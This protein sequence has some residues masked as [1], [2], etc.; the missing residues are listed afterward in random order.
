MQLGADKVELRSH[1]GGV[2]AMGELAGRGG[3]CWKLEQPLLLAAVT[4]RPV[5]R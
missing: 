2:V 3:R 4:G 1:S 5:F